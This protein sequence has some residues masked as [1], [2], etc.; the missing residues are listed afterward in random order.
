MSQQGF[1]AGGQISSTDL[2]QIAYNS[3]TGQISGGFLSINAGDNTKLDLTAGFAIVADKFTDPLNPTYKTVSWL[4]KTAITL[5]NIATESVTFIAIDPDDP[6][7]DVIQRSTIFPVEDTRDVPILGDC[8]HPAGVILDIADITRI[9][10]AYLGEDMAHA[11]QLVNSTGNEYEAAST[12]LTIAKL[13]GVSFAPSS[14][15]ENNDKNPH[16]RTSAL[17]SPATFTTAYS[18]GAG[19]AVFTP[20]QTDIDPELWD[21]GSGTLAAVSSNKWTNKWIYFFPNVGV[22]GLTVVLY[23]EKEYNLQITAEAAITTRPS[24]ITNL[25]DSFIRSVLTV[26]KGETDLSSAEAAFHFTSR[27]GL[28]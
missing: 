2:K 11:I 12:D 5:T 9:A 3:M 22:N 23:G 1:N 6:N 25:D 8:I 14:N 13:A 10:D 24:L 19:G 7:G 4:A 17:V 21:D 26:K 16:N 28:L 18:D 15:R 27:F 20:G